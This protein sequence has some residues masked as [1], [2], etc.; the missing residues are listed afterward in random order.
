MGYEVRWARGSGAMIFFAEQ[1]NRFVS[2]DAGQGRDAFVFDDD[3]LNSGTFI[4]ADGKQAA[5]RR[6]E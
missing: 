5:L 3:N 6:L 2:E 1:G 4:R